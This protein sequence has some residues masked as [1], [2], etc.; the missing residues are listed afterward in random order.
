MG[1]SHAVGVFSEISNANT[2]GR[3]MPVTLDV[4]FY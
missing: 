1:S 4:G 2:I 3:R